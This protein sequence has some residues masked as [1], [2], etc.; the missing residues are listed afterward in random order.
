[1]GLVMVD[2]LLDRCKH[3]LAEDPADLVTYLY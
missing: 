2:V 3:R 1:V